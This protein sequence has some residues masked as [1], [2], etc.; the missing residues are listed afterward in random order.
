[1]WYHYVIGAFVLVAAIRT[2]YS[3]VMGPKTLMGTAITGVGL[4]IA[5]MILS[6]CYAAINAPAP[7]IQ[8]PAALTEQIGGRRRR[9][10]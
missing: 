8:L 3:F 6:W 7:L 4:V 5:Y 1:M 9:R 10:R 2:V